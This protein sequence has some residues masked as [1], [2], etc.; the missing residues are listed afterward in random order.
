MNQINKTNE[1]REYDS[2]KTATWRK[3]ILLSH[4]ALKKLMIKYCLKYESIT[5]R[6]LWE[7]R[8]LIQFIFI[9][10]IR[11]TL[12]RVLSCDMCDILLPD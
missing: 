8:W 12:L 2:F 10:V 9:N 11:Y 3:S 6:K 4:I 5:S 7:H 1:I